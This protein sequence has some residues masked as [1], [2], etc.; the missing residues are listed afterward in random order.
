MQGEREKG[1]GWCTC[2]YMC[3]RR[4]LC[5]NGRRTFSSFGENE[6]TGEEEDPRD[7]SPEQCTHSSLAPIPRSPL[8]ARHTRRSQ[9]SLPFPSAAGTH[10]SPLTSSSWASPVPS[11]QWLPHCVLCP[12]QC[13]L[14]SCCKQQVV[15]LCNTAVPHAIA[16]ASAFG[17]SNKGISISGL[18]HS[19]PSNHIPPRHCTLQRRPLCNAA[20]HQIHQHH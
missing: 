19:P 4:V 1:R 8:V 2:V 18:A 14:Q 7:L 3:T 11:G 5:I 6:R 12:S 13:Y 10:H 9:G 15:T 16:V 20:H 17:S